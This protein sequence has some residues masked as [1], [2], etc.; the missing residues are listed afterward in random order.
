MIKMEVKPSCCYG[1]PCYHHYTGTIPQKITGAYLKPGCHY[2]TGGKS[3]HIFKQRELKTGQVPSWCP[4]LIRPSIMRVY[5]YKDHDTPLFKLL[6]NFRGVA[7]MPM[8]HDYALRYEGRLDLS[9]MEL[10]ELMLEKPLEQ[11][12]GMPAELN[13]VIEIYDG[14]TANYFWVKDIFALD[15]IYFDGERARLNKLEV[16]Q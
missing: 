9:A 14:L 6:L 11:L 12:L 10:N 16:V 15:C 1:R 2:C 3:V 5:Q 4:Q 8:A 7:D 13:E